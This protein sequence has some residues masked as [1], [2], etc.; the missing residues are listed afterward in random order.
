MSDTGNIYVQALGVLW[1]TNPSLGAAGTNQVLWFLPC[2]FWS[3]I[4]YRLFSKFLVNRKRIISVLV[5]SGCFLSGFAL[6]VIQVRVT[7]LLPMNFP[8][9]II[10]CSYIIM[11]SLMKK[12]IERIDVD[13][14]CR[15]LIIM[16]AIAIIFTFGM[17]KRIGY[18]VMALSQY[19]HHILYIIT[20]FVALMVVSIIAR[21]LEKIP[22]TDFFGKNTLYILAS[23]Y[24]VFRITIPI[25]N[26]LISVGMN[27]IFVPL[28]NAVI[29]FLLAIPAIFLVNK[30]CPFINGKVR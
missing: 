29:V 16:C 8:S 1:G 23:H 25:M 28:I 7:Y 11:G 21:L 20:V 17:S 22:L 14:Y 12:F 6:S 5:M 15:Y 9:A 10:G 30:L 26:K 19:Q 24:T 13:K 27:S 2:F 4:I 18:I 3:V